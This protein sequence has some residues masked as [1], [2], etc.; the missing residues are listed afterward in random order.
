MYT[1]RN[2]LIYTHL[3]DQESTALNVIYE[4]KDEIRDIAFNY[5]HRTNVKFMHTLKLYLCGHTDVFDV[6]FMYDEESYTF[7]QFMS[8]CKCQSKM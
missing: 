4:A 7:H 6:S 5:N 1:L 8:D 2:H 3:Y